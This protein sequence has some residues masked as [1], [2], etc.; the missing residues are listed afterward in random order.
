M[1]VALGSARLSPLAPAAKRREPI[2]AA[3]PIH[4]VLTGER[5]YCIVSYIARPTKSN[6]VQQKF[7]LNKTTYRVLFKPFGP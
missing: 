6:L 3:W 1:I 2:E 4:M 5:M 7:I